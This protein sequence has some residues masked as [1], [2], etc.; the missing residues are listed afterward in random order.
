MISWPA[1]LSARAAVDVV[2]ILCVLGCFSACSPRQASPAKLNDTGITW[3]A[4]YPK[5]NRR[6]CQG[7]I[8]DGGERSGISGIDNAGDIISYQ[9]CN[10]GLDRLQQEQG[11]DGLAQFKYLRFDY[12]GATLTSDS[13]MRAACVFDE[14]S[15]LL[16]ELKL[17]ADGVAG[18][19]GM[20]DSDDLYTWYNS[21][22]KINGGAIGDWNSDMAQC[23]GYVRGQPT[24]YCNTE[25]YLNRI[26][27]Q[28]LCG[29]RDWRLPS[30][31]ELQSLVHYGRTEPAID[32]GFFP[33][34]QNKFYWSLS[35]FA[36]HS[37]SAWAV[38]FQFGYAAPVQRNNARALRLVRQGRPDR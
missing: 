22:P 1:R 28:G 5:G 38:N 15:G 33:A 3:G 21:S 4:D 24:T 12:R 6:S 16:W 11:L 31:I 37:G 14:V 13:Q 35:P 8:V 19:Q 34:T 10:Q 30:R 7:A 17:S 27:R 29:A 36:Q 2:A 9:D 18:N 32:V 20:H 26:N 25:E 23:T